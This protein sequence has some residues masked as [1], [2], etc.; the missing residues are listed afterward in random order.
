M[1]LLIY[2]YATPSKVKKSITPDVSKISTASNSKLL[3]NYNLTINYI[4]IYSEESYGFML[5]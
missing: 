2:S 4:D 3:L 5:K 1:Q